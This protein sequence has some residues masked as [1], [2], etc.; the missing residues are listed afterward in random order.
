MLKML[1]PEE[2]SGGKLLIHKRFIAVDSDIM[3]MDSY[4][5]AAA[6]GDY[7]DSG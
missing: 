2:F 4:L 6:W 1:A 3:V 5:I 7:P